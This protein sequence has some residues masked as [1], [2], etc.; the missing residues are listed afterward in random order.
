MHNIVKKSLFFTLLLSSGIGLA[1]APYY[2]I[3]S[4]SEN[5]ARELVGAGWNTQINLC[6]M[7]KWYGNFAIT[8]E[9]TRSFKPQRICDCLFGCWSTCGYCGPCGTSCC[10][11]S[12]SSCCYPCGTSC[13]TSCGTCCDNDCCSIKVSGSQVAN[14]GCYDWL[15]DHFGLPTDYQS[16]VTFSPRIDNFL[17][18]FNFYLGMDEWCSGMYFRI[19]APVVNTRWNLNMC[20]CVCDCGDED[21]WP[22]Y[23]NETLSLSAT[24]TLGIVRSNLV[25]SFT[26]F[27]TGCGVINDPTI[28]FNP[29]CYAKM[30]TCRRKET[31]LSD[32]QMALGWNFWCDE[33]YHVGLN[34]RAVAPTGNRPEGCYLFEPIVGNGKHWELGGGFTTHWTFWRSED[35]ER[36]CAF[37]FDANVSHLFKAKQVRTF[38]LCSKPLSRYMLAAKFTTPVVNLLAGADGLQTEPSKQF[39]GI[40]APVANLTT[41]SVDVS[42][43]V[44][45]DL[46][47]MFQY[48]HNNWSFDLGYNFWGKSCEKIDCRCDC[49]PCFC[50]NTWGLKGDA[51]M[52]G[53]L[54]EEEVLQTPGIALSATQSQATLFAGCNNYPT[55]NTTADPDIL[56]AQNPYVDNPA[57]AWD[58][59]S[60][61]LYIYTNPHVDASVGPIYTSQDPVFIRFCDIDFNGAR[62][63][64]LSHKLFANF[65]YTW[66]DREDWIPYL[67]FGGEV[68]FGQSCCD[69]SCCYPCGT[70]CYGTSCCGTSCCGT[71]CCYPCG[72]DSSCCTPCYNDSSCNACAISQW[73]LWL[74]GGVAFN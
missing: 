27:I 19:H 34:I 39:A 74:K 40:Y 38:D 48:L 4:Q 25:S 65:D 16:N 44:Q 50:E 73:G 57:L 59:T 26:S 61:A 3:R 68:E 8:A 9:Y 70:S 42:V 62:T 15:A 30:D 72:T 23:F 54:A 64:G 41:M 1:V 7:D 49:C 17:V 32:I 22:G 71:S 24:Q 35:E 20:E 12:C 58:A 53:F 2:S 28:T 60:V 46:A 56:W 36:S 67:G 37:F 31:A 55:G 14:R 18:D 51:F 11:S 6:D 47:F 10:D 45:A 43:G 52:Y 21:H 63:K 69:D 13:G 29:L 33:D 66:R 5:A